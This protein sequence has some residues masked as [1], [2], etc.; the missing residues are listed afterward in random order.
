[1]VL[2]HFCDYYTFAISK[3]KKNISY[4]IKYNLPYINQQ[5]R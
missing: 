1:M 3:T 2:L 5:N 4:E